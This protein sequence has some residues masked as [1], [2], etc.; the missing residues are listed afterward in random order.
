MTDSTPSTNPSATAA[1]A[2]VHV[3]FHGDTIDATRAPD[4]RVWVS[5][6]R[7]CEALGLGYSSQLQK[8]KEKPWATVTL[9]VMVAADGKSRETACLDL[10]ALPMW[11][12][13]IDTRRVKGA[14]RE[15]L[16]VYQR[17]AARVLRDYFLGARSS[18]PEP[19]TVSGVVAQPQTITQEEILGWAFGKTQDFDDCLTSKAGVHFSNV[20][21]V[22]MGEKPGSKL[23]LAAQVLSD[24]GRE[25]R[26]LEATLLCS[27]DDEGHELLDRVQILRVV[28][29][30]ARR[31]QAVARLQGDMATADSNSGKLN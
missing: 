5:V 14:A 24:L 7:V 9:I 29:S 2:V 30:M 26:M 21:R 25:L 13:T 1:P 16:V 23:P 3:P 18:E 8:L 12:A 6:S 17:E 11:L 20:V 28:D 4:G 15:K 22:A 19:P 10:D 31:A 27:L